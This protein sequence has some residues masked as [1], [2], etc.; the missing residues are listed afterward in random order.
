M[1]LVGEEHLRRVVGEYLEYNHVERNHQGLD[2]R[3]IEPRL[4]VGAA[5]GKVRRRRRLGGMLTYYYRDAA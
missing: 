3:I 4:E 2:S 5:V 1:I